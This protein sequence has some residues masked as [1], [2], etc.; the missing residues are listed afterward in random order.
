MPESLIGSQSIEWSEREGTRG[1]ENG[2]RFNANIENSVNSKH[3]L[4]NKRGREG[5]KNFP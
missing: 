5:D 4:V 1:H 2:K 3:E